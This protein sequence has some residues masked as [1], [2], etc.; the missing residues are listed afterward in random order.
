MCF[1]FVPLEKNRDCAAY[2][3]VPQFSVISDPFKNHDNKTLRPTTISVG[4]ATLHYTGWSVILQGGSSNQHLRGR[5][6]NASLHRLT[7]CSFVVL[8]SLVIQSTSP[9]AELQ[10]FS[11]QA[12]L[13]LLLFTEV[14]LIQSTSPWAEHRFPTPADVILSSS[15]NYCWLNLN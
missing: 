15:I 4:G 8:S 1:Y 6:Y 2:K 3:C 13:L 14:C 10:C 9:W 11:T 7:C 12:D 5:S